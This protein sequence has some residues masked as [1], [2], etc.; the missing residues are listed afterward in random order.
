MMYMV[1][2]GGDNDDDDDNDDNNDDDNNII[3]VNDNDNNDDVKGMTKQTPGKHTTRKHTPT[4]TR[5]NIHAV[6]DP[7]A[8]VCLYAASSI[9][10]GACAPGAVVRAAARA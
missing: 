3:I 5:T 9:V 4:T 2:G 10:C 7:R 8:V 1:S 6:H